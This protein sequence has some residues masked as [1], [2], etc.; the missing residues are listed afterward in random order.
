MAHQATKMTA[1]PPDH[2]ESENQRKIAARAY[3]FWL[4]RAFRRGSPETDWLRADREV[5][6]KTGTVRLKRTTAGNF[7][8]S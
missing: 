2:P 3:E 6:G 1:T 7:L 8:L 5:R 4:A